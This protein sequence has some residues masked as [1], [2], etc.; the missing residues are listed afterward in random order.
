MSTLAVLIK[1]L[2]ADQVVSLWE[3]FTRAQLSWLEG[4]FV[5]FTADS[6][7]PQLQEFVHKY[8]T[9]ITD[10]RQQIADSQQVDPTCP[11]AHMVLR[12][13][14]MLQDIEKDHTQTLVDVL[15]DPR[16]TLSQ[17]R[18]KRALTHL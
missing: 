6:W 8:I 5:E 3:K 4:L 16:T 1:K 18:I 2:T 15:E 12:A 9:Y 14:Q 7:S 10:V 11:L 17:S 13:T